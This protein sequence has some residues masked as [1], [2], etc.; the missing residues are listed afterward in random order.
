MTISF[1]TI[2]ERKG[3]IEKNYV[4]I[5]AALLYFFFGSLF[6]CSGYFQSLDCEVYNSAVEGVLNGSFEIYTFRGSSLVSPPHGNTFDYPGMP[7]Y[8]MVPPT[9]FAKL[10]NKNP[11][12]F[13]GL[14]FI[15]LDILCVWEIRRTI[16][17]I[18][19]DI[20]P[21]IIEFISVALFGSYTLIYTSSFLNHFDSFFVYCMI[22][23][24]R[25][26]NTNKFISGIFFGLGLATKQV[27]VIGLIP[28]GM[29]LLFNNWNNRL[30]KENLRFYAPLII[31]FS[32]IFLP[33]FIADPEGA[34][35]G[36]FDQ[37]N[38]RTIAW[39]S[40]YRLLELLTFYET[41]TPVI[42][43]LLSFFQTYSNYLIIISTLISTSLVMKYNF[44]KNLTYLFGLF[45]LAFLLIPLLGKWSL[46]SYALPALI[47]FVIWDTL[48]VNKTYFFPFFSIAFL[49]LMGRLYDFESGKLI[50][51]DNQPS[52]ASVF[53][54][55]VLYFSGFLY[56]FSRMMKEKYKN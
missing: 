2:A 9:L 33:F 29:F 49:I 53:G 34:T 51:F 25:Y 12:I 50:T 36:V 17:H 40:C 11:C 39:W 14:F 20:S 5:L 7:V 4:F 43:K 38:N 24:I 44:Q 47:F 15:L 13:L 45:T 41:L 19:P 46:A 26:I 32:M 37:Q 55:F 48:R 56:V 21:K 18:K 54:S 35:W 30:V 3:I 1:K 22:I 28:L 16:K 10:I 42:I 8:L 31:I 23:G 6:H 52:Y 27:V